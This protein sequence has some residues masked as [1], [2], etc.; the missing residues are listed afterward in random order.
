MKNF[1]FLCSLPRAGN[2]LLASLLNQNTNIKVSPYSI[3]PNMVM[4]MIKYKQEPTFQAFPDHSL[5]DNVVNNLLSNMYKDWDTPNIIDR[6]PWG[7]PLIYNTTKNLVPNPKYIILYRPILEVL[8]SI[9]DIEQPEDPV[10][11]CD[12]IMRDS[13]VKDGYKSI[14]NLLDQEANCLV[15][16][17]DDI[18]SDTRHVVKSICDFLETPFEE[19][20]LKNFDQ[21][22]INGMQYNDSLFF[23]KYH[24]IKTNSIVKSSRNLDNL[25]KEVIDRHSS[26]ELF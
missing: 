11:F 3:A 13:F 6:G 2:T 10:K 9:I 23:G 7:H 24:E 25:P 22:N 17:Y 26:W 20:K 5:I 18:L 16:H 12:E 14:Q 19:P 15:I 8:S 4:S 21:F 1:H